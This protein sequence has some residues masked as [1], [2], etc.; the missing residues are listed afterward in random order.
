MLEIHSKAYQEQF[1]D[2][3]ICIIPTNIYAEN[4]N[5]NIE[6]GHVIPSLI[7][8]YYIAKKN[9]DKFTIYFF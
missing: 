2:N 6:D 1:G 4:N 9:N 8:K 7:H 3:F 5:Y